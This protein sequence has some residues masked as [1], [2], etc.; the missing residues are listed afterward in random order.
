MYEVSGRKQLFIDDRFI[1]SQEGLSQRMNPPVKVGAA[2]PPEPPLGS[3]HVNPYRNPFISVHEDPKATGRYLMYYC[4]RQEAGELASTTSWPPSKVSQLQEGVEIRDDLFRAVSEDGIHWERE[5]VGIFEIGGNRDNNAVVPNIS[6]EGTVFL[7]PK[8]SPGQQFKLLTNLYWPD[9]NKAGLYIYTSADGVHWT[10]QPTRLVPLC[11]DTHNQVFYD[12][13][14]DKYVAYLRLWNPIR[15]AGRCEIND[16]MQPW[17]YI[18]AEKPFFI[19]GADNIPVPS[20]E[21]PIVLSYDDNDPP[22]TD[23]YT[24]SVN[25]YPYADDVYVAFPS[26]YRHYDN[27]DPHGRDH[28]GK[29]DNDGIL[30]IQLAVSRDGINFTRFQ[31]PY[32]GLGRIGEVDGGTLYM[33]LGMIRRGDDLYQYYSAL[34]TSHGVYAEADEL[35]WTVY[36]EQSAEVLK[37]LPRE[38]IMRAVQRLDGFVSVD[39]GPEGGELTTPVITFEGSRLQ[40]NINCSA[41]GEAWVELQDENGQPIAGFSESEAVSVDRNGVAQEVWWHNG[42]DVSSL[43]GRPIKMRIRMRSA[44]LFAFQFV[45]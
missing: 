8:A 30:E 1:A 13:R 11:P 22:D 25:L 20:T 24:P 16:V 7:D 31:E 12:V 4:Q 10:F 29:Y 34:P 6:I 19:W 45:Q 38:A 43:A 39:A 3:G 32:V 27:Y 21:F 42:P 18:P 35:H 9:P 5:P 37:G 33:G 26:L 36:D 14:L 2:L 17:P 40:L 28:R 41:M 23:V 44:K 15:K